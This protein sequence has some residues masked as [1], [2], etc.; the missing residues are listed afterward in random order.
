MN[1]NKKTIW[2]TGASSG[3]GK[4]VALEISVEKA[5][6]ILSGRNRD[7]LQK[8]ADECEKNGSTVIIVPFDLGDEE[9]V[10]EAAK[11]VIAQQLKID[12]LYHFGGISQRSFVSETPL[13][14]DRKLFEINYFGTIALTKAILPEMI[15]NGGGQI[16][17]TSS[18]VGKFG[19]P[20]RS[21]YSASKHALHG[22]FESLR[23]ENVRNNIRVSIIVPGRIKTN[24]SINAINKDGKTH[25]KMDEGQDKGMSAERSAK[26]ICRKLKQEKKKKKKP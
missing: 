11:Q 25:A 13:F 3:I 24:I 14:V 19:F 2:I 18:I 5:H 7:A 26:V 23:A 16:A 20:Y 1:F 12:A 4:A 8:V 9:S 22:F 6:L 10:N 15:K 17:V 21:S